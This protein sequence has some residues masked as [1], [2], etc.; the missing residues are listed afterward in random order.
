MISPTIISMISPAIFPV[1]LKAN[2]YKPSIDMVAWH[3]QSSVRIIVA[4]WQHLNQ[5]WLLISNIEQ[6]FARNY[7]LLKKSYRIK[8]LNEV[9]DLFN[10]EKPIWTSIEVKIL[11]ILDKWFQENK[12]YQD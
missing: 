5:Q 8:S 11:K 12:P 10:L 1:Q 2:Q 4:N 9:V 6:S 3:F 7:A